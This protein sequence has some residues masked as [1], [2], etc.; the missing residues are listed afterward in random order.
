MV[1]KIAVPELGGSWSGP[2]LPNQA[3]SGLVSGAFRTVYLGHYAF[4]GF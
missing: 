2:E 3:K 1:Q 4:I